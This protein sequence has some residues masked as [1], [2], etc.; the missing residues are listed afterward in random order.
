MSA[1]RRFWD[2]ATVAVEPQGYT[3]RLDAKPMRIPGGN[4]L[5]LRSRTLADAIAAEWQAAGGAKGGPL[6][7]DALPL[8]QLASTAQDR[9]A[10]NPAPTV[11]ALAR[12]AE[13]DLLCYR[14]AHPERL[15][16]RQARSWQPWL[17]W[18]HGRH[19]ARLEPTE[20]IAFRPQD[21]TALARIHAVLT[22]HTPEALAA[23][24]IAIPA[25]GSAV[26]GL[27]LADGA[28]DAR[29]A[30]D[31]ASLDETF[32]VEAWGDD[33]EAAHRRATAAADVALA[34]R[35]LHLSASP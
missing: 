2:E 31:A 32:E 34:E 20:G 19:G 26:L 35:F 6:A 25:L 3:I 10:P 18:L 12:Y 8:T 22:A 4:P 33:P 28:I 27:A 16:I 11:D 15:V 7:I 14:A 21:A 5:T 30:H 1:M 9:I 24:G 17:D 23:L 29:Q 13:T